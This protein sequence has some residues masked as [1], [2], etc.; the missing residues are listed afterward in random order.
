MNN[1]NTP[2][3]SVDT[4]KKSNS[5]LGMDFSNL[6]P[7]KL[8]KAYSLMNPQSNT[9]TNSTSGLSAFGNALSGIANAYMATD[10]FNLDKDNPSANTNKPTA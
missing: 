3:P 1:P 5:F 7:E 9:N 8:M 2:A 10:G 4:T 6:D